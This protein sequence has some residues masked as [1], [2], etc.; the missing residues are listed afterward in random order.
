MGEG[1]RAQISILSR[2]NK[3]RNNDLK[4]LTQRFE[5]T[6]AELNSKF[7]EKNNEWCS[8]LEELTQRHETK[9]MEHKLRFAQHNELDHMGA[10]PVLQIAKCSDRESTERHLQLQDLESHVKTEI[11]TIY[12]THLKGVVCYCVRIGAPFVCFFFLKHM[13][14][15]QRTF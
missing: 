12:K 8:Q 6:S 1:L 13:R 14:V 4:E 15:T 2:D 10:A 11:K 7:K 9:L 5:Q 3:V